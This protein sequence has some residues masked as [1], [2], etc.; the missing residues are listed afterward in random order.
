MNKIF[1]CYFGSQMYGT[2]TPSSDTD[3]K[4]I[5][6]SPITDI[7]LNKSQPVIVKKTKD[8]YSQ[9]NTKDDVDT[10]YKEL[11]T[12]L[13]E[14]SE[15]Q[16]Y[17]LDMLFCPEQST[18]ISSPLW[19]KIQ[20]NRLKLISKQCKPILGYVT[21]QCAKY[22][23]KGSRLDA[24][25]K[26]LEW[27]KSKDQLSKIG[28]VVDDFPEVSQVVD[29]ENHIISQ[30]DFHINCRVNGREV[31]QS[32]ISVCG[33]KFDYKVKIKLMTDSL[34]LFLEK[35]GSRSRDAK[36]NQ[37][38]DWKAVSH[39]VRLLFQTQELAETGNIVFPLK[40]REFILAVKQGKY[41]WDFINEWVSKNIDISFSA[42]KNSKYLLDKP[43]QE[44]IESLIIK[45]YLE[46]T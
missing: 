45:T 10:E 11:R 46:E 9:K 36:D 38:I 32:F 7:L 18:I 34:T 43:D 16:T 6:I 44:W 25:E 1:E 19:L 23:M 22:A 37:G 8:D 20:E 3:I 26:A 35:F 28:E 15:G 21:G 24:V 17:A 30:K 2:N 40:E 13:R 33:I 5:Y 31:D 41:T 4:G 39:A 12:F 27:A 29:G 42:I 14:A